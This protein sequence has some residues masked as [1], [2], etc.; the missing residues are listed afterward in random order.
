L[1]NRYRLVLQ[2]TAF[3]AFTAL[4]APAAWGRETKTSALD[5]R[6]ILLLT[7]GRWQQAAD[8]FGQALA[9][10]PKDARAYANRCTARYKLGQYEAAIAD[11]EAAIRLQPKLKAS[12]AA[13]MSDAYYRRARGR[14]E[15]GA[16]TAATADLYQS[17]RLDRKNAAAY[18][19]L[20]FLAIRGGQYDIALPYLNRAILLAPNL[21]AAY[22]NRAS[23]LTA[24]AR[25]AEARKDAARAVEL[26]PSQRPA[27]AHLLTPGK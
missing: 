12:L 19:E 6:G 24:L 22:A 3:C 14:V 18:C 17:V 25:E 23:A 11:F 20:G 7:Q 10:D 5:R 27:L 13:S 21:A 1:V 26:D 8:L 2:I 15:K 16:D 4:A 9:L